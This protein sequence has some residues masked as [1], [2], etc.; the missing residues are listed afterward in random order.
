M[1]EGRNDVTGEGIAGG[2]RTF[3]EEKQLR[4]VTGGTLTVKDAGIRSTIDRLTIDDG[5]LAN[6]K[7]FGQ[8]RP[9]FAARMDTGEQRPMPRR[10]KLQAG[11]RRHQKALYHRDFAQKQPPS[12]AGANGFTCFHTHLS[13]MNGPNPPQPGQE[14]PAQSARV[15]PGFGILTFTRTHSAGATIPACNATL[16]GSWPPSSP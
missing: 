6:L 3:G 15:P 5:K 14:A 11:P 16:A 7:E 2:R 12:E 4:A 9:S 13:L 8:I 1:A 10:R